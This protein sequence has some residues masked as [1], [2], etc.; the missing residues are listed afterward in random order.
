MKQRHENRWSAEDVNAWQQQHGWFCGFNY[1]PRTAVNWNEMWQSDSFD[2][3]TIEQEL[4][5]AKAV[6]FNVVRTNLP[7]IV[8]QHE[9]DALL[10]NVKRFL[11]VCKRH[12]LSVILTL[13]DDC[14]FSGNSP[15][16][17]EQP[18]PS[19]G[20]HNSQALASPGREHVMN[21][22]IWSDI[23]RYTKDVISQFQHDPRIALW[24]LYNEPTNR[25]MFKDGIH[26]EFSPELEIYSHQLMENMFRWA[27]D[28]APVQPL[29]VAAWHAELDTPFDHPTDQRALALSDV[30]TFHAYVSPASMQ[31]VITTLRDVNR[32]ILCTEWMARHLESTYQKQLPMLKENNIGAVQWGLVKGK[33]QTWLPWPWVTPTDNQQA[34]WFHDLLDESGSP[35]DPNEVALIQQMTKHKNEGI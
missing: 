17:G 29:T 6:G 23:E 30:I 34:L 24:D 32:P 14:E 26:R 7:F 35:F 18:A 9:R 21:R 2:L 13:L 5:W 12:G 3:T 20:V 25:M 19:E 4:N 31:N 22:E 8:W 11:S 15:L 33:T 1:L 16:Y 10:C 28:V 27:R